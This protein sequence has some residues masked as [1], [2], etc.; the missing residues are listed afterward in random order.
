M[1]KAFFGCLGVAAVSVLLQFTPAN[2]QAHGLFSPCDPACNPCDEVQ[3]DPCDPCGSN[4]RVPAKAGRFFLN[5]HM[6]AGFF[7]NSHG[8]VAHYHESGGG[9]IRGRGY[10]FASGNTENL[11]N[12]RLTGAQVNQVYLSMADADWTSVERS[13]SLGVVM[14]I[15]CKPEGWNSEQDMDSMVLTKVVGAP[16]ITLLPSHRHTLK[17]PITDGIS[18]PVNFSLRS[19]ATV[20]SP[21]KISS[22]RGL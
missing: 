1:R 6:E 14:P 8:N 3:C 10:C 9:F 19:E 5:G 18:L 17:L 15:G 22:T 4:G 2:V 12:T 7:A 11:Q 20:T 21:Q 16:A 13:I